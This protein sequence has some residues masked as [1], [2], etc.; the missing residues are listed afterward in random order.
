MIP[1]K[2]DGDRDEISLRLLGF[3]VA[4]LAIIVIIILFKVNSVVNALP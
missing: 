1:Q 3:L 2:A 4:P